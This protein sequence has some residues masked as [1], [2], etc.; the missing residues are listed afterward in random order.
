MGNPIISVIIPVYNEEKYIDRCMNS[1]QMQTYRNLQIILINGG[2]QDLSPQKCDEWAAHW[3]MGRNMGIVEVIHAVNNGVSASRNLGL[4]HASGEYVTFIDGDDWLEP[5]A[6]EKM[7]RAIC[8]ENSDLAGMAFAAKS[9]EDDIADTGE[10]PEV[11]TLDAD[12]FIKNRLLEGDV[13]CWGRLYKKSILGRQRFME[14]LTIGEDMLFFLEYVLK[15]HS[16]TCMEYV[17]YNYF[18]NPNGAM[19]RPYTPS[20]YDQVV[21][22]QKAGKLLEKFADSDIDDKVKK[23]VLI[24]IMLTAGR[25]AVLPNSERK[26]YTN[27]KKGENGDTIRRLKGEIK[28][29][30]TRNAVKKL[31]AGYRI[32]LAL[33]RVS[34]K[35]YL[36]LYHSHKA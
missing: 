1:L 2:S 5:D 31:S 9:S 3:N 16:I 26:Q 12:T 33:F 8:D 20:A 10:N 6:I 32:K 27:P 11:L 15:C 23:N 21:C 29:N 34:P 30:K 4:A 28:N 7:Y 35:L 14:G 19:T 25:I 17:G 36:A 18:T 22:W 13:H 24:S